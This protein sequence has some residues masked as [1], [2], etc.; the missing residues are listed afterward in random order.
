[1]SSP[2]REKELETLDRLI[3]FCNKHDE[4]HNIIHNEIVPILFKLPIHRLVGLKKGLRRE[5][6]RNERIT[7]EPNRATTSGRK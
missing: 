7:N 4:T 5:L 6:K 2:D 1:M 3:K